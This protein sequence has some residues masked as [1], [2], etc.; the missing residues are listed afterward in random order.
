MPTLKINCWTRLSSAELDVK[1]T[2]E[3]AG[4]PLRDSGAKHRSLIPFGFP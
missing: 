2:A 1:E 3:Q 4:S